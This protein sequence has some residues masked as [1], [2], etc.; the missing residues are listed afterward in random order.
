MYTGS[1]SSNMQMF[2][3]TSLMILGGWGMEWISASS[4]LVI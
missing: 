3:I 4:Y 1:T 2:F